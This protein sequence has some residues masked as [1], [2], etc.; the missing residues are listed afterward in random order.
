MGVSTIAASVR[1]AMRTKRK[2]PPAGQGLGQGRVLRGTQGLSRRNCSA[3]TAES[4]GPST[5]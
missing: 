5:Q 1:L 2:A 4:K 3:S